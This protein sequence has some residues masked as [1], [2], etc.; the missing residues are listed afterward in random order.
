MSAPSVHHWLAGDEFNATRMNE[1]GTMIGWIRNAPMVHVAR[2]N[3]G[4]AISSNTWTKISFDN[5][6]N[7]YDTYG[8]FDFGNPDKVTITQA[9]W[10]TCELQFSAA[11]GVDSRAIIAIYKNGFTS[12]E[13]LL[14]YDQTTLP[15]GTNV[16]IRKEST[17]F[18]NVGDWLHYGVFCDASA[19]TTA[20]LSDAETC[21]MKV[22]WVSN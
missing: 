14:R 9:G 18:F 4:Q 11:I 20:I 19:F 6:Y 15:S 12:N 5:V 10:Y 2:R 17:F 1:I 16:N 3:T 21:A 8:F 7:G 13:L 22:R